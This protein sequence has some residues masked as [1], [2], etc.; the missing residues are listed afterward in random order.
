MVPGMTERERL[1]ADVK[2]LEWL[3]DAVLGPRQPPRPPTPPGVPSGVRI[4]VP[5]DLCRRG[6]TIVAGLGR[7]I[8]TT[9]PSLDW[10]PP[11]GVTG[12]ERA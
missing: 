6:F 2:R 5:L 11:T 9:R 1:A 8:R 7:R 12:Q 10:P 4:S 3:S